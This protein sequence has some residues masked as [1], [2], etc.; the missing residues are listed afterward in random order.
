MNSTRRVPLLAALAL[1]AFASSALAQGTRQGP[2]VGREQMWPAATAEEWKK[3]VL[4]KFQRSW[5]DAVAVSKRTNRPIL[6]CINMDG[7]IASEHYAGI[8]YRQ[9]DAA[10]LYENYVCVIA[11][12]YRHTPRDYDEQ[13]RRILCP[14]F[15]CVTCGEHIAIE[16]V[17]YE[18]FCNGERV[19]PRHIAVDLNGKEVWDV[20]YI[21][22]TASVFDS[23]R[24]KVP[25]DDKRQ[26]ISIVR[27]DRPIVERV[28]SRHILDREAVEKAYRQGDAKLRQA[29]L[30]E[31][32][33][34]RGSEQLDLLRLAIFGLDTELSKRARG[35][36]AEVETKD[37][38]ELVSEAL[39]VPMEAGERRALIAALKRLGTASPLAQWL[40]GAH[41]GLAAKSTRINTDG[42]RKSAGG[43]KYPAPKASF[44]GHGR[45]D[46]VEDVARG[47]AERPDDPAAHV[48]LA[49]ATLALALK[50]PLRYASN[51][52]MARLAARH[53]FGDAM[54]YA[55][56]ARKLGTP[57]WRVE[58]V[59][60]LAKYYRGQKQA[61]YPH[62]EK[63]MKG[64]P[65][66]D[67]GWNSMAVVTIFAESRWTALKAAVK[68]KKDYPP[69]W[70]TDLNAAYE[71]LLRHPLGTAKQVS[72]HYDLLK[73]L[74]ARRR[75]S[76]V[77]MEG[78][79]RFR[80]APELHQRLRQ[81]LILFRGPD[82]L[83]E[84]YEK[85]VNDLD[86]PG[87]VGP[88]AGRASIFA[89][90]Y[91]RRMWRFER[92]LISYNRAIA[93]HEAAIEGD[94]RNKDA[95][96]HAI[97]LAHA[98]RARV[99]LQLSDDDRALLEILESFQR[100]KQS[101]GT[102]DGIGITPG[103]T[104]QMLLARLKKR[105]KT[106]QAKQLEEA[107]KSLDQELLRPDIG[108]GP[109]RGRRPRAGAGSNESGQ[110]G[111]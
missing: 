44:G 17:I 109:R 70:L 46:H 64:L 82:G 97:A 30:D 16:P 79:K 108:L 63:A 69:E 111:G 54:K 27:G 10:K 100:R 102:R 80:D 59:L 15:G 75:A 43:G 31:A 101:A 105:E 41:A 83:E 21:N 89:A 51:P 36:L 28:A 92:A 1:A 96:T 60:A 26:P 90:E 68:A 50:A 2:N 18:K 86:D 35:T 39:R 94:P 9:P 22:D 93:H 107:L 47:A 20:Y 87:R 56:E 76:Q 5:K 58:T 11:S 71:V 67:N 33:K 38:T 6:V 103:E 45:L 77:L 4:I 32:R 19:A 34:Q 84:R 66:G 7:E 98:A 85:L 49:E 12:V 23:I 62:A 106:D 3:P 52:R 95:S 48:E 88:F 72:W 13:G 24:D 29:L 81:R 110:G 73:W 65:P 78:L 91:H 99:Y 14:R 8:R 57:E 104:A 53:L 61:A 74:R 55:E 40:A 37:A 25:T 42:W